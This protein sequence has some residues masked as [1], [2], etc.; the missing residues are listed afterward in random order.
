VAL[1]FSAKRPGMSLD[2]EPVRLSFDYKSANGGP[3]PEA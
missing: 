3:L 2:L 1:D